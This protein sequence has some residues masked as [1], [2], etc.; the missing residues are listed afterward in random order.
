MARPINDIYNQILSTISTNV[1]LKDKLT[2]TTSKSIFRNYS[3]IISI[4]LNYFETLMDG[5]SSDLVTYTNSTINGTSYYLYN[6]ALLFEYG[7][8]LTI[9]P[10]TYTAVYSTPDVQS[11]I[12]KLCIIQQ[13]PTSNVIN[14]LVAKQGTTP[15]TYQPL[16]SDEISQLQGYVN[17]VFPLSGLRYL[18]FSYPS[19]ILTFNISYNYD[20]NKYLPDDINNSIIQNINDYI[21]GI[22][23][24]FIPS[25]G[26]FDVIKFLG[27]ISNTTGVISIQSNSRADIIKIT[28]FQNGSSTG[29]DI[30][31]FENDCI[32]KPSISLYS[33]YLTLGTYTLTP[34][35]I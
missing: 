22:P 21:S 28:E 17:Q 35:P 16:N 7:N 30:T 5:K 13:S 31:L 2:N 29:T 18:I 14:V 12:V 6:K 32:L 1:N 9:D 11:R 34:V 27:I 25:N 19:D 8:S 23:K 24:N 20:S 4:I 26:I 15:T 33:G 10:L 3:Y